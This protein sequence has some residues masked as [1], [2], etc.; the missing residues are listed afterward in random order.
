[1]PRRW[2]GAGRP[3]EQHC[4]AARTRQARRRP[5]RT[6]PGLLRVHPLQLRL[7]RGDLPAG[8]P[9][10]PT[11]AR[12]TSAYFSSGSPD[13]CSGSTASSVTNAAPGRPVPPRAAPPPSSR[14]RPAVPHPAAAGDP[15][16]NG[17]VGR[18][19]ERRR[20]ERVELGPGQPRPLHASLSAS[21]STRSTGSE[22]SLGLTCPLLPACPARLAA[23]WPSASR[24]RGPLPERTGAPRA[25]FM[26]RRRAEPGRGCT[27]RR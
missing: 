23:R 22:R 26:P 19:A 5:G 12:I 21:R 3:V 9:A 15:A 14:A 16:R 25:G 11:R 27:A 10:S 17:G 4:G 8:R 18:H 6:P 20:T 7:D 13:T 1:L 2:S 24:A